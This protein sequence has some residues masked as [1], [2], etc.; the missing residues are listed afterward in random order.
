[1]RMMIVV[2]AA[3]AVLPACISD[4]GSKARLPNYVTSKGTRRPQS[5]TTPSGEPRCPCVAC[6]GSFARWAAPAHQPRT[7]KSTP[8]VGSVRCSL[9]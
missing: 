3:S 8:L 1:M 9:L 6:R 7:Q 4:S 2:L 5:A